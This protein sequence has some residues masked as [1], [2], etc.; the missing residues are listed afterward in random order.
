[1]KVR[2]RRSGSARTRSGCALAAAL[3]ATSIR[4]A[5]ALGTERLHTMLPDAPIASCPAG[6]LYQERVSAKWE[7]RVLSAEGGIVPSV[8]M[9]AVHRSGRVE[10]FDVGLWPVGWRILRLGLT[11][12]KRVRAAAIRIA[13]AGTGFGQ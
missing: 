6:I 1:M 5:L 11:I 8:G 10:G 9:E 12:P 7:L 2:A 4:A 13:A 3:S